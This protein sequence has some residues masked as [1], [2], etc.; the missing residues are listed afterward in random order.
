MKLNLLI[1]LVLSMFGYSLNANWIAD[2]RHDAMVNETNE[3]RKAIDGDIVNIHLIYE[4]NQN[5]LFDE[6]TANVQRIMDIY[7]TRLTLTEKAI[8]K[9]HEFE[10]LDDL[11]SPR[12]KKG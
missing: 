1:L 5:M 8:K 2:Q 10:T 12:K 7:G 11:T 4:V 6:V 9:Y 3:Y